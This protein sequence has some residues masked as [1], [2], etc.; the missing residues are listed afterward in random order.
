MPIFITLIPLLEKCTHTHAG[1]SLSLE[2][3]FEWS[4]HPG[5]GAHETWPLPSAL[6][7]G[8]FQSQ[9]S[10]QELRKPYARLDPSSRKIRSPRSRPMPA[11]TPYG[12]GGGL[13]AVETRPLIHL[14][15][16]NVWYDQ[17]VAL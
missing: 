16:T 7:R 2:L 11:M 3:E 9:I 6:M 4:C 12:A 14:K 5:L 17:A 10:R 13:T 15:K 1:K 8:D